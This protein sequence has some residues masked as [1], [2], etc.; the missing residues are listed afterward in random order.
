MLQVIAL[1]SFFA[2]SVSVWV[3]SCARQDSVEEIKTGRT[4]AAIELICDVLSANYAESHQFPLDQ[5]DFVR[6]LVNSPDALLRASVLTDQWGR[7]IWYTKIEGGVVVHST[8]ADIHESA[9]DLAC[10]LRVD[11]EES[12]IIRV[13]LNL[14]GRRSER[15]IR[16]IGEYLLQVK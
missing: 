4:S 11:E 12:S 8:G 15:V 7:Q 1:R 9:D 3:I 10:R 2:L 13:S 14:Y 5:T 16:P 6:S